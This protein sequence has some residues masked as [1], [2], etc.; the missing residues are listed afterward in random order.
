MALTF[1]GVDD[2]VSSA[3]FVGG[4]TF[5]MG[6]WFNATSQGES[7]NAVV[8]IHGD[9]T[10][11]RGAVRWNAPV[12]SRLEFAANWSG[13]SGFGRWHMSSSFS[14]ISQWNWA[15]VTYD[16]GATTNDPILYTLDVNTFS[17]LT[18][19]SG[20]T[21][22]VTPVGTITADNRIFSA[23]NIDDTSRTFAG[24]IGEVFMYN[25][26]LSA[27]EARA[28]AFLGVHAVPSGL[29]LYWP[30]D[31]G[32]SSCIDFSGNG[33][34]GTVT[35]ATASSNPPPVRPSGRKG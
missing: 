8:V 31:T 13:G 17:T 23:G 15:M 11:V 5:S 22:D 34:T 6:G 9:A 1:D 32:T 4:D 2:I 20:L 19:G 21:E 3:A 25:R 18:V 12:T 29:M 14:T 26:I 28:I 16:T 30:M 35:G 7:N 33:R 24:A 10:G 27:E